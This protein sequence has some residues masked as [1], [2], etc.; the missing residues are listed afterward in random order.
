MLSKL[1]AAHGHT[2]DE[3]E[4]GAVGVTKATAAVAA[5]RPYSAILMDFVM[6]VMDGPTATRGKSLVRRSLRRESLCSIIP[7]TLATGM[8]ERGITCPI[9]GV[10]GNGLETDIKVRASSRPI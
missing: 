4:N 10:T 2:V 6:P 3:A 5:G 1:L 8:R 7:K 9:I